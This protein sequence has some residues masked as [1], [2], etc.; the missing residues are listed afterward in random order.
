[1]EK[2]TQHRMFSGE[3]CRYR[4]HA[5]STN[6]TMTFSIYLPDKIRDAALPVLYW[7]SG[8]TCTDENF[9]QKAGA[10]RVASE[11]GW[12]IVA[13]DTSPRGET[14]ADHEAYDLGQGA[15]FYVNATKSPWASH[16]Q[17]YDY[18]VK[19]LPEL[20]G[21]HFP[22]NEKKALS[23]HSMGGH[24]ALMIGLKNPH[25]YDSIS[26][27][28]PIT[29]PVACPWGEKAFRHYLGD[30]KKEWEEYDSTLLLRSFDHHNKPPIL[31]DQGAEDEFLQAQLK[32][33]ALVETAKTKAYPLTYREQKGFDHS[34]Y[35]VAS[36]MADHLRFHHSV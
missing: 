22:V 12:I 28:S 10:Q 14:V 29:N 33:S 35:F 9:T 18:I 26:A 24:G 3:Q 15:S 5:K 19:E 25:R 4:H 16:F 36:F 11:L 23:G 30:D 32:P 6:T 17:M 1:M 7:L 2:L 31:I 8:L 27:F 21:Q 20:V 34:Y 13:P